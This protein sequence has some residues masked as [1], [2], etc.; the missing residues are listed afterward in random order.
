MA[1]PDERSDA[2]A[3]V[4]HAP[5]GSPGPAGAPAKGA[6][7][8]GVELR[9]RQPKAIQHALHVL[10]EVARIGPGVTAQQ[11][12]RSLGMPRATAYRLL[13][14]LV[15]EEYL[16]RLPDLSGF[17]LGSKVTQLATLV[18][19]PP[20][21]R[22]VRRVVEELRGSVRA[23]VHLV[24][25][26][27]GILH[28]VDADPDFPFSD[29]VRISRDPHVSALGALL[30]D[31][32]RDHARMDSPIDRGRACLAVPIRDDR[33]TLVAG[34]ALASTPARLADP[35]PARATLVDAAAR[36]EPLLA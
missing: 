11:V 1:A 27:G 3:S 7:V 13:N 21:P 9:A 31:P 24:R 17:A 5:G 19:T 32:S 16:V 28:I 23:G 25:Y 22:A 36:L 35:G 8:G 14:L 20:P 33:G 2:A 29:E 12:S 15:Q 30:L 6:A 34:L 26:D 18:P 10:E 4:A